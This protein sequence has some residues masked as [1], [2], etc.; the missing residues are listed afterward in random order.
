MNNVLLFNRDGK[1]PHHR[2]TDKIIPHI[3]THEELFT[4]IQDEILYQWNKNANRNELNKFIASYIPEWALL[5]DGDYANNVHDIS[6][7]E[8]KLNIYPIIFGPAS[9]V[10]N[11]NGWLV[12]STIG[13]QL[14]FSPNDMQSEAS[15]RSHHL[16]LFILL[17]CA[18]QS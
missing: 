14:I 12:A 17:T 15:A 6:L 2:E 5:P 11:P 18:I 7:V 3:K 13:K 16:L 9:S 1:L 10:N 8:Q 4:E